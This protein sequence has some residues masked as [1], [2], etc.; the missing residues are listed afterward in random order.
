VLL[1]RTNACKWDNSITTVIRD[2]G[3]MDYQSNTI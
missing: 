2:W 3:Q 1:K